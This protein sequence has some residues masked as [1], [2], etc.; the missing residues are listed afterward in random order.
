LVWVIKAIESL[1]P[2]KG[3]VDKDKPKTPGD[4]FYESN[5]GF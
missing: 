4:K 1:T 3:V 5:I 2:L